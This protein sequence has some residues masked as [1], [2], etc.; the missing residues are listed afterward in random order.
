VLSIVLSVRNTRHLAALC[1]S[2]MARAIGALGWPPAEFLLI[3]DAS[4]PAQGV[5]QLFADFRQR[6]PSGVPATVMRFKQRQHYTRALAYGFSAARGD[7]VLFVSH[8]MLLTAEYVRTLLAVAALDRSIGL[9]RGT[10]PYVDGFPQHVVCPPGPIRNFDELE[11]FARSVSA[12][13]GLRYE[14]DPFLTGDSMLIKREVL[15]RIGVFDPRYPGYFGDVDFGL[16]LLRAG[17]RMVCAKGAWLGHE[18]AGVYK[19]QSQRTGGRRGAVRDDRM[20][21]VADAYRLFREK[22]DPTLPPEYPVAGLDFARLRSVPPPAGGEF[23]P[24]MAPPDA[25]VCEVT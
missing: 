19:D 7:Q 14:E 23:V 25:S 11:A 5:P 21:A 22:W 4:E 3:D 6:L 17:F 9:V 8:D 1:L 15:D 10:S 18:G 16:R 13:A 24:P 20:A 12:S 2:S